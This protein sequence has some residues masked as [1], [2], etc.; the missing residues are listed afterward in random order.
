MT[1]P[2]LPVE[3]SAA[4]ALRSQ[5]P[6]EGAFRIASWP[7]SNA[8]PYL[9]LFY[10]ALAPHGVKHVPEFRFSPRWLWK[11]GDNLDAVHFHWPEWLWSGRRDRP[12]R[13]LAK[14]LTFLLVA[15]LRGVKVLWT[16]H[17]LDP[18][19]GAGWADGPA[20][21]ALA[22][23]ADL[24]ILHSASA[25][26]TYRSRYHP[27]GRVVVMPHGSYLGHYP[28]A[29]PRGEVAAEV[30]LDPSRPVVACLGHLRDYKGLPVA[31]D[32]VAHLGG[33]V[34][35]LVAGQPH[36]EFDIDD[37][38][39]RVDTIPGATLVARELSDA[40]FSDMASVA[41][42]VLL[43]YSR[44]TGSGALLAA[45]SLGRAVVASDL[46][47]FREIAEPAGDAIWLCPPGDALAFAEAIQRALSVP[48]AERESAALGMAEQY[49][50]T[51]CV[52]PVADEIGT[53][54]GRAPSV[55]SA[56][57]AGSRLPRTP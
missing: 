55:S 7:P 28:T 23:S 57:G 13:A 24:A 18:H 51:A 29:R 56:H 49:A 5:T 34:Q 20:R 21:S 33:D 36:G 17:N 12:A 40:E 42:L 54:R 2:P 1:T 9:D 43:P 25:A 30:G 10:D 19:E 41:D 50:W 8:N 37:L 15:R 38:S 16:V 3:T 35:L 14:L 53:W 45:W 27:S 6:A 47:F 48:A 46:P 31:C 52:Q 32:A 39:R 22:R 4:H 44:I 11:V 26:Q